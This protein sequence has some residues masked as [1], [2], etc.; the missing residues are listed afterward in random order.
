MSTVPVH[1]PRCGRSLSNA[2]LHVLCQRALDLEPP[3][4][5]IN[6]GRRMKVQV[7]PAGWRAE[8]VE[9]GIS[10]SSTPS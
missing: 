7:V 3:R 8:C 10:T 4:Y 5:C 9:H 2:L 6:C 1:C